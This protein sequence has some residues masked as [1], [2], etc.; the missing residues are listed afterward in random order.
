ATSS[1]YTSS[2][3]NTPHTSLIRSNI[4]HLYAGTSIGASNACVYDHDTTGCGAS[5]KLCL[6]TAA[7]CV[8]VDLVVWA[9]HP[10]EF[11]SFS[12]TSTYVDLK[13][14]LR[15]SD[16]APV[17]TPVIPIKS[18]VA[19]DSIYVLLQPTVYQTHAPAVPGI[20][21]QVTPDAGPFSSPPYYVTFFHP[22]GFRCDYP[23]GSGCPT[24]HRELGAF[25]DDAEKL[26]DST[27]DFR[28]LDAGADGPQGDVTLDAADPF[29]TTVINIQAYIDLHRRSGDVHI[30]TNGFVIATEKARVG[31][32]PGDL[33]VGQIVSTDGDVTLY[34]PGAILDADEDFAQVAYDT[35]VDA[36]ADVV[37]RNITMTAGDN[38]GAPARNGDPG[39][40]SGHGGVGV[41][42]NFLE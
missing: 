9:A 42:K 37:G 35:I 29:G 32:N 31:N 17:G 2:P 36:N 12:G 10:E 13:T 40:I 11:T 8:N 14:L 26:V 24:P 25:A 38:N 6:D 30:H 1:P 23:A 18:M 41:P 5:P 39:T 4:V 34:A 28:I 15:D 33:R 20:N 19:G 7:P 3:P 16:S 21:V 22:D 27:Y